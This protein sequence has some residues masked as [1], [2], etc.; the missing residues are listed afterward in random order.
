MIAQSAGSPQIP[1]GL[2]ISH[3][4]CDKI[5]QSAAEKRSR[6]QNSWTIGG[7]PTITE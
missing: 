3:E 6:T 1:N 4:N 2:R 5:H 7:V